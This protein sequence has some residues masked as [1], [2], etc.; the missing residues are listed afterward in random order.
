MAKQN[1]YHAYC[2]LFNVKNPPRPSDQHGPPKKKP[3]PWRKGSCGFL[4]REV[5]G[6]IQVKDPETRLVA[7]GESVPLA[8]GRLRDLLREERR[9]HWHKGS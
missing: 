9:P 1:S 7:T 2:S 3:V 5:D 8:T 4:T 6:Q